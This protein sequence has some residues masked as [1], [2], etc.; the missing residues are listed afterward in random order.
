MKKYIKSKDVILSSIK[1]VSDVSKL[2]EDQLLSILDEYTQPN[3]M[4]GSFDNNDEISS[5]FC[6]LDRLEELGYE[7]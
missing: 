6:V 5:F 7:V 3:G 1:T 2:S 4:Y